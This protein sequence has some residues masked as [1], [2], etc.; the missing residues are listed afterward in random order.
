MTTLPVRNTKTC[1]IQESKDTKAIPRIYG[2]LRS[3]VTG[4]IADN[5]V[6]VDKAKKVGQN[7]LKTMTYKNTEEYTFKKDKQAITRDTYM[8]SEVIR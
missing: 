3:I 1:R 5:R 6:N 7:I 4:V 8:I 2:T